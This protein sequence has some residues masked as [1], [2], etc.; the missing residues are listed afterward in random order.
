MPTV[1]GGRPALHLGGFSV[2]AAHHT[3]CAWGLHDQRWALGDKGHCFEA[4][5][6]K[7]A[8]PR[9]P[10]LRLASPHADQ[11]HNGVSIAA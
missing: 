9:N 10:W 2:C 8:E 5:M 6:E 1:R 4:L 11:R 7:D 3:D